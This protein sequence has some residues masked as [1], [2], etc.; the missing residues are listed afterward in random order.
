MYS[1]ITLKTKCKA[2][3]LTTQ[4]TLHNLSW[5]AGH[6]APPPEFSL[7]IMTKRV[8]FPLELQVDHAL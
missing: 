2:T 1:E 5:F 7:S 3:H 4:S 8:S 6:A